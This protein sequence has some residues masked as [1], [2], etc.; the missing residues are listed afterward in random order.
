[1]SN[2]QT[3]EKKLTP[4]QKRRRKALAFLKNYVN[5]YDKQA[6]WD[7]LTESGFIKDMVYGI[8]V[9]L[10]EEK[11]SYANGFE[12]FQARLLDVLDPKGNAT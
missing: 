9:A 10:D 4:E 8:G 7:D 11:Y 5:T 12:R 2:A 6:A 3:S 1:M